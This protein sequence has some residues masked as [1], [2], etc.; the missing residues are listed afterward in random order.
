MTQPKLHIW[1]KERERFKNQLIDI[2][3]L[4]FERIEPVFA[5]PEGDA[6]TYNKELNQ[7]AMQTDDSGDLIGDP[8]DLVEWVNEKS[9]ARYSL[10]EIMKYRTLAMWIACMCQVW[11]QQMTYFL[12]RELKASGLEVLRQV[13]TQRK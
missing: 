11:E 7:V 4:F 1:D 5:D 9:F 2:K 13:L 3:E 10:L 12:K 6:Q 8:L